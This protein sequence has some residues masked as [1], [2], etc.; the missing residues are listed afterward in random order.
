[1]S[2]LLVLIDI[3]GT[4]LHPGM[5]P[6]YALAE[7]V[8]RYT[9]KKI[10]FTVPQ[11]AGMTDPLI[12]NNALDFL[13]VPV[14]NRDGLPDRILKSYLENLSRRYIQAND[15]RL[16][17]GVVDL[18]N[19]L[20][21]QPVRLGLI[22]GNLKQ[23]AM[24]KL[25]PFNLEKYFSMGVFSSD[26][27]DRDRLPPI[28]LEKCRQL[29]NEDYQPKQV[30]IIGDTTRDVWCAH[31]NGMRAVAVIRHAD[32]RASIVAEKPDLIVNGFEKIDP[33]KNY[34]ATLIG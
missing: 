5:T 3:D 33:I 7:A 29:F 32:R 16:Y 31:R 4:M 27:P 14:E 24:I 8:Y 9:G 21:E 15:W 10:K 20:Q 30:V 6:R 23:G 22:T 11:L 17:P 19:Y 1:M 18:L 26:H 34:L 13:N 25:K 2:K 12:V 28:A